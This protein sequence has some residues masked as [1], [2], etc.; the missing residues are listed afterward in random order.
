[1]KGWGVRYIQGEII[2]LKRAAAYP[3][4]SSDNQREESIEAQM[5]YINEYAKQ[6]GY[7][8]VKVYADEAKTATSDRR[9]AFQ[10]MMKDASKGLFEYVIVHKLDRFSRDRY[11]FAYYKRLLKKNGVRLVSVLENLDDSPES[12]MMESVLEGM[13]EYYSKN[14]SREVMRKGMIPNAE[15][16]KHNGGVP[17][18]GYDV[19]PDGR[20]VINEREAEAVR[21]IFK[22]YLEDAGYSHICDWLEENGIK[23][24]RGGYIAKNS[25]HDI[26][27]NEKYAGV[28]I[29]NRT[30]AKDAYG[31]RNNRKNKNSGDIIRIEGG[32]PAIISKETYEKAM[33]KMSKNKSGKHRA[34]EPYL[35]SGIIFCGKCGGAMVGSSRGLHK[36]KN[37]TKQRYYE[38]NYK[39]RVK[40]CDLKA[41]KRDDIENA[42]IQY[43]ENLVTKDTVDDVSGWLNEN[44]KIYMKSMRSE[45]KT[46]KSE[47]ATATRTVEKI[48]DKI[49]DGLDS[50]AARARL[51]EAED[52]KFKLELRVA[53]LE[54]YSDNRVPISKASIKKY[55]SQ[56]QGLR[57]KDRT[58]QAA[59]IKQF[60]SKVIVHDR[61][62]ENPDRQ[63]TI[64]TNLQ[65]TTLDG[66]YTADYPLLTEGVFLA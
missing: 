40:T 38:C 18:L 7:D 34:E 50:E 33:M 16:C 58:E 44:A 8:I 25:I 24:K 19:G 42:V 28:Y 31:R 30:T 39:K 4:Y 59:I 45:L 10:E 62:P 56:L 46:A 21:Y 41:I 17:P 12:V 57:Y 5:K 13:A 20:Y 14:L 66:G 49:L 54:S 2:M 26:L 27:I 53:E 37:E 29:Y 55:L 61:D 51:K 23:S 22:A 60:V 15:K 1:M 32:M 6:N 11:D 43:L 63:F 48:L 65:I 35:L 64:K 52:K 9:P 36:D 3:R 47:L